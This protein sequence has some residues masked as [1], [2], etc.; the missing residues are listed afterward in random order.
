MVY[1]FL[2]LLLEYDIRLKILLSKKK[3]NHENSLL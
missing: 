3:K 1:A 2:C